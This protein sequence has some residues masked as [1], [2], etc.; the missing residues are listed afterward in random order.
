MK[1]E[2]HPSVSIFFCPLVWRCEAGTTYLAEEL[3]LE[4]PDLA[5]TDA[6]CLNSLIA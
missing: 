2:T 6:L 4:V 1:E 5:N 3:A